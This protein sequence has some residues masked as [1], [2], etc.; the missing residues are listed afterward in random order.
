MLLSAAS[1][2]EFVTTPEQQENTNEMQARAK[3]NNKMFSKYNVI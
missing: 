1:L 2:C 3:S